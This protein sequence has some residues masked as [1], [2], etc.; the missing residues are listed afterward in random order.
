MAAAITPKTLPGTEEAYRKRLK[1][2]K[3]EVEKKSG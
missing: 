3:D 1:D 2:L